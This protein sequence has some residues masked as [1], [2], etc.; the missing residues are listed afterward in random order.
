MKHTDL[1]VS[2]VVRNSS[3]LGLVSF[4]MLAT[5]TVKRRGNKDQ[6][7]LPCGLDQNQHESLIKTTF[8]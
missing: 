4:T 1:N 7:V 2:L 8:K 5:F 3:D 6:H